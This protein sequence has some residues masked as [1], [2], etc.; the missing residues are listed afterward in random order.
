VR[1]FKLAQGNG[2]ILG[3]P[4]ILALGL[5]LSLWHPLFDTF[6]ITAFL[7]LPKKAT[8]NTDKMASPRAS[9]QPSF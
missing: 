4:V 1:S 6:M 7:L 8:A 5:S 9:V 3:S 2:Q